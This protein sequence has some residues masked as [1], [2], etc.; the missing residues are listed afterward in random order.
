LAIDCHIGKFGNTGETER[1]LYPKTVGAR[2]H[3]TDTGN[4]KEDGEVAM[5]RVQPGESALYLE[6]TSI[7]GGPSAVRNHRE[8]KAQR[9]FD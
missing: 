8:G 6:N 2:R 3:S 9:I 1:L 5:D 7:R 4:A